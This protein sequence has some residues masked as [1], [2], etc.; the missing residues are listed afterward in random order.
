MNNTGNYKQWIADVYHC[1][2]NW[3]QK[4]TVKEMYIELSESRK[5]C[6]PDDYVPDKRLSKQCADYW[7]KLCEL[8]PA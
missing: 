1:S 7:N 8:Y 6:S 3:G 2:E 5:Q 4:I